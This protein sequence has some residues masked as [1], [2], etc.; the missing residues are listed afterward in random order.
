MAMNNSFPRTPLLILSVQ[1]QVQTL[2]KRKDAHTV[3]VLQDWSTFRWSR[4]TLLSDPAAKMIRMKVHVFQDSTSCV[5]VSNPDPS[6]NWVAKLDEVW[7]EHGFD[8]RL[9]SVSREVQF[10][11]HVYPDTLLTSRSIFRCV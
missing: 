3:R 2:T 9:N 5:G 7:N 4:M 10:V 6:N 1:R 8:D 11:W